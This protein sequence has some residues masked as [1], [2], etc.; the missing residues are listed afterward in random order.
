MECKTDFLIKINIFF[1]YSLNLII[2][3]INTSSGCKV[4][5]VYIYICVKVLVRCVRLV[6]YVS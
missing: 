4:S 5:K 2:I 6:R 1:K 3:F